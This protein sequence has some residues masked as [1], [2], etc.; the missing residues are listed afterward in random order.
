MHTAMALTLLLIPR[1]TWASPSLGFW[2]E[3]VGRRVTLLDGKW[4]YGLH[5]RGE[6]LGHC[7][8]V[9]GQVIG[10]GSINSAD[11]AS[12]WECCS[13]C[14]ENAGCLA[15]TFEAAT[16]E[17]VLK[18]NAEPGDTKE[19]A[20]SGLVAVAIDSMDPSFAPS[21]TLTPNE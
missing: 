1:S 11:V 17:C 5:L 8:F 6:K 7:G 4:E 12:K 14:Q 20:A 10:T 16:G 3:Y 19:G 15:F 18:N 21:Q 9:E 2:P 13:W